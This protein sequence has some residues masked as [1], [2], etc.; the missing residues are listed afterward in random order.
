[1][2]AKAPETVQVGVLHWNTLMS[3]SQVTSSPVVFPVRA[4]ARAAKETPLGASP[5]LP[6][7]RA[8]PGGKAS[9]ES[10]AIRT[11]GFITLLELTSVSIKRKGRG[12]HR[13]D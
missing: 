4:S 7:S 1:M 8:S 3:E 5:R 12:F 9:P 11:T 2:P 10:L 13:V 6:G